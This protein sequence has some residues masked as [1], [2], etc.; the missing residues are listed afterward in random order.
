[1]KRST[2]LNII[3]FILI[4][5]CASLAALYG[6]RSPASFENAARTAV[7]SLSIIFGLTAAMSSL[8]H[9][10]NKR[11]GNLSNDPKVAERIGAQLVHDDNRSLLRQGALHITALLSIILGLVY[12]VALKDAPNSVV[13][14]SIT[15][16][17]VFGTTVSLLSTLFLPKLLTTLVKRNAHI[18]SKSA[19]D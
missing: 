7:S 19:H 8:L 18:H 13:T 5:I 16:A 2:S 11:P 17:F 1:M 14:K 4:L 9:V 3:A 15:A 6:F 10:N 12:L